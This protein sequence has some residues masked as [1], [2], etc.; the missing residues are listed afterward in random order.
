VLAA[1]CNCAVVGHAYQKLASKL[2]HLAAVS[3]FQR[4]LTPLHASKLGTLPWN[5]CNKHS[6][7]ASKLVL[8]FA[9]VAHLGG[10]QMASTSWSQMPAIAPATK[11]PKPHDYASF[12]SSKQSP[13]PRNGL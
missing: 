12:R 2:L 4:Q 11:I 1:C 7:Y 3:P 8:W 6:M 13:S 9:A 10:L 5:A